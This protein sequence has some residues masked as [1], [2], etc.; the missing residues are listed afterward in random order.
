MVEYLLLLMMITAFVLVGLNTFIKRGHEVTE[1]TFS[2]ISAGI[3]GDPP[4]SASH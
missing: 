3:M 4:K 2:A 1:N